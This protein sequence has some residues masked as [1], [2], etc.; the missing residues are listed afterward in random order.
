MRA[1]LVIALLV[2][3]AS[4][5][6]N[7]RDDGTPK[8]FATYPGSRELCRQHVSGNKM[9][10]IWSSHASRDELAKVVAFYEKALGKKA[11]AE[12]NGAKA[13]QA[14]AN[15]HV[16]IYPVASEGRLPTCTKKSMAGE[17]TIVMLSHA[18]R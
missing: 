12:A 7:A 17:K 16:T 5:E 10:I 14:D 15:R 9:H 3:T 1:L 6:E 4:A 8:G 11:K 13:I 18:I 2:G